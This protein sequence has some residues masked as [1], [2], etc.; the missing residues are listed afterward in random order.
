MPHVGQEVLVP[1]R[2]VLIELLGQ[3][4]GLDEFG[5]PIRERIPRDAERFLEVIELRH[6]EKGISEDDHRPY[7]AEH[8]GGASK[9]SM[10]NSTF[11]VPSVHACN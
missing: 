7:V 9:Q 6:S 3:N 4:S 1:G 2:V 11:R 5:E 10:A 8:F